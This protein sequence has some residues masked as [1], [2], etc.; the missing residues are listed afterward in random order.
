MLAA[1]HIFMPRE[2]KSRFAGPGVGRISAF[3]GALARRCE[4]ARGCNHKESAQP[5]LA[6]A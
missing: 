5:V 1:R 4:L 6:E 2:K 3:G